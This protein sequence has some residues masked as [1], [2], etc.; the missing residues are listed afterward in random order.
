MIKI[1]EDSIIEIKSIEQFQVLKETHNREQRVITFC[2]CGEFRVSSL[3]FAEF[4]FICKKCKTGKENYNLSKALKST[5]GI[6]IDENNIQ[7]SCAECENIDKI[8]KESFHRVINKY[9]KYLCFACRKN[10]NLANRKSNKGVKLTEEQKLQRAKNREYNLI[11]KYGSVENF[12]K[13][14]SNTCKENY[15]RLS[16]EEKELLYKKQKQ[17]MLDK[18]GVDNP[19]YVE[20]IKN[21]VISQMDYQSNIEKAKKTIIDTY[22]SLENFYTDRFEKI[23]QSNME[24]YGVEFN[25]QRDDIK[26]KIKQTSLD[27]Y[28]MANGGGSIESLKKA[29]D[30]WNKKYNVDNVFQLQEVKE[31]S[32]KT[33][34][35]KYGK[36]YYTQT[37]A[38]QQSVHKKYLY[39]NIRFDSSWELAFYIYCIDNGLDIKRCPDSFTYITQ[40]GKEHFYTPDFI[41]ND[42]IYEIKGDHLFN[43]SGELGFLGQ[44]KDKEK[45][46]IIQENNIILITNRDIS[47]YLDYIANKYGKG[48][49]KKFKSK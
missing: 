21:K 12:K 15:N 37:D 3:R 2:T 39:N 40:D 35:E 23:K 29:K 14:V 17:G 42:K 9:H 24:K 1:L 11:Q 18:Y 28:G 26:E 36:E 30:T 47:K 20:D 43:E 38:Y 46:K 33:C 10:L 25:W 13:C 4:P 32:K 45:Y 8:E 31:K 49:L 48:Y 19:M 22:G 16:E 34:L 6:L 27:K 41:V 5:K 7:V 44:E